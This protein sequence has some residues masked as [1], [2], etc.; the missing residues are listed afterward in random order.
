VACVFAAFGIRWLLKPLLLDHAPL[1]FFVL[2]A[3]VAALYGGLGPAL[4]AVAV[5][6]VFGCAFFIAPFHT[7]S[8]DAIEWTYVGTFLAESLMLVFIAEALRRWRVRAERSYSLAQNRGEQLRKSL[9]EIGEAEGKIRELASVLESAQDSLIT[10]DLDGKVTNWSAGAQRM[11]GYTAAEMLGQPLLTLVPA[12]RRDE[13][14]K[15]NEILERGQH[16]ESF[17]TSRL[18]KDGR[19]IA[20]SVSLW[21][22]HDSN[23]NLQSISTITRDITALRRADAAVRESEQRFQLLADAAPLMICV[24]DAKQQCIWANKAWLA[25]TG[26]TLP[27]E[28]NLGWIEAVDPED[29]PRCLE[30]QK[31]SIESRQPFELEYRLKRHDG[32]SRWMFERGVPRLAPDNT[33][34]GCV[35]TC[36]DVTERREAQ[37]ALENKFAEL[38]GIQEALSAQNQELAASREELK[39]ERGRYQELFDS[40]PAAY[41]T[42]N[43]QGVIEQ[44]NSAAAILL[45]ETPAM[46]QGLPLAQLLSREAR[47]LYFAR[48]NRLSSQPADT[49]ERWETTIQKRQGTPIACSLLANRIED[50]HGKLTGLRW[51][52]RDISERKQAEEKTLRLNAELEERVRQRTADLEAANRELEA[53]S[54]SVSHD[55]RAPLRSVTGF[56]R[57]LL[58]D[59]GEK[60]DADGARFLQQTY[61][62]GLRM[63]RLIDDL[64]KLSRSTR[65]ELRLREVGLSHLAESIV[66]ELRKRDPERNVEVTIA[67]DLV[68]CGDEGLLR[69]AMENLMSNSWKFTNRRLDDKIEIVA[70][71]KNGS[72]V[73]FIKDNGAGFNMAQVGRLFSVFQRLHS[74]EDFPGTG[75]GLA[76][77]RRIF[78]RHGGEVWAEGKPNEGATFYF[79]LPNGVPNQLEEPRKAA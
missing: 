67:P 50:H 75:I 26:S 49:I 15:F 16:V 5:G 13:L 25:F 30:V 35:R 68:A 32:Q 20:V 8:H 36:L 58:E 56:S 57:A 60:L 4:T 44:V 53:F 69:I 77:V 9:R 62:A 34:L 22:V 73:Y 51:I 7:S 38:R 28:L 55:L 29:R 43:P 74:Q 71:S 76:T 42:T 21:P 2:S 47:P 40:A 45:D 18:A 64:I 27:Q 61:E 46:L 14:T 72:W 78:G 11:F 24:M 79:T 31:N 33:L 70:L 1:D 19:E 52:V 48:L 59:Y 37:E 6:V 41:I 66:G 17:E 23:G 54:Y 39:T 10:S 3:V 65:G 12:D 63:N